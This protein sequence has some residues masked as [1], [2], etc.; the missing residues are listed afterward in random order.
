MAAKRMTQHSYNYDFNNAQPL[1]LPSFFWLFA[2]DHFL[3]GS[4]NNN[5][6]QYHVMIYCKNNKEGL[7]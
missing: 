1:R 6:Y 5:K 3:N 4:I 2:D 7:N